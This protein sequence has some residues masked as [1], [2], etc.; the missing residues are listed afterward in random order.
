MPEFLCFVCLCL[1]SVY[2][3]IPSVFLLT[4]NLGYFF[5]PFLSDKRRPGYELYHPPQQRSF[6][7]TSTRPVQNSHNW[8]RKSSTTS[9]SSDIAVNDKVSTAAFHF[10]FWDRD[11]VFLCQA[12]FDRVLRGPEVNSNLQKLYSCRVYPLSDECT[13]RIHKHFAISFHFFKRQVHFC[14]PERKILFLYATVQK[15]QFRLVFIFFSF[16]FYSWVPQVMEVR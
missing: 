11:E 1:R 12:L 7:T 5:L 9:Q 16:F 15:L 10:S 13:L 14:G 3:V 8:S 4:L 6:G 2:S